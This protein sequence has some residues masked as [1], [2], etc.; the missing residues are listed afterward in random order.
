MTAA[1]LH[2]Y[3]RAAHAACRYWAP[4]CGRNRQGNA[5]DTPY[6]ALPVSANRYWRIWRNRAVRSAEA[7][8]YRETV[9]RIA[10]GRARCRPKARLPYMCG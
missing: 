9:R 6:P 5:R 2:G 1:R 10:Q 7:A 3:I 4:A 8:A